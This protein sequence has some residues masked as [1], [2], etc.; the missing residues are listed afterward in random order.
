MAYSTSRKHNLLALHPALRCARH[1]VSCQCMQHFAHCVNSFEL[2][3]PLLVG[4][5]HGSIFLWQGGRGLWDWTACRSLDGHCTRWEPGLLA[6]RLP[7]AGAG[8]VL[9]RCLAGAGQSASRCWADDRQVLGWCQ[10]GGGQ[11]LAGGS[12]MLH[13]QHRWPWCF[14]LPSQGPV[15][16]HKQHSFMGELA[17]PDVLA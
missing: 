9:G 15:Q 16:H 14:Y 2:R 11:V 3:H 13:M 17:H 12:H 5:G 8:Q 7:R 4:A 1:R 6:P 10:A